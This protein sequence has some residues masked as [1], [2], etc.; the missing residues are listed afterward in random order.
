MNL[1]KS[2]EASCIKFNDL[3][4][5]FKHLTLLCN[6]IINELIG[7]KFKNVEK[8]FIKLYKILGSYLIKFNNL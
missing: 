2:L 3:E 7:V 4:S 1:Y 5:F 8:N 6:A